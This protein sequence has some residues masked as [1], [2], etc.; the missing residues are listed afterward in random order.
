MLTLQ[1]EK[2]H[3]VAPNGIDKMW[4]YWPADSANVQ[5]RWQQGK[6]AQPRQRLGTPEEANE[7][8]QYLLFEQGWN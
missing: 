2:I 4:F 5:I 1:Q 3:I 6:T 8:L 7:W